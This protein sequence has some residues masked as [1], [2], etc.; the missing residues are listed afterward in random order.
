MQNVS[1]KFKPFKGS[2]HPDF[3]IY[4]KFNGKKPQARVAIFSYLETAAKRTVI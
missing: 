2:Q 3:C 1:L 4:L